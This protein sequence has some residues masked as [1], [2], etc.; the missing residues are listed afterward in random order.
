M[1]ITE[2]LF[3]PTKT[4]QLYNVHFEVPWWVKW[5]CVDIKCGLIYGSETEPLKLPGGEFD[6]RLGGNVQVL[7]RATFK[8]GENKR[9]LEAERNR[10]RRKKAKKKPLI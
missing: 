9:I 5:I 1:K 3:E 10:P 4:V 6:W 2:Q 7:Y 8:P